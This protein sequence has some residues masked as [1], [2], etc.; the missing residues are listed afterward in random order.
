MMITS[1][2]NIILSGGSISDE[3]VLALAD[4][5]GNPELREA[6]KEITEKLTSSAFDSCSIINARS[7]RCGENCKWCAQSAHYDTHCDVYDLVDENECMRAAK[8]N[9]DAGVHRFSMVASGKATR[10]VALDKICSMLRRIKDEVGIFTCASLGLLS[11][12]ELQKL[13]DAGVRRYHCNLEAAPEFFSTLCTTHTAED[14]I[15]TILAA[16]KIGFEICS[17][18]IIGMGENMKQRAELAVALRRIEPVSIPVNIL[19]PI[20]GT[21]LE[22]AKPLSADEFLDTLAI[23]R[24]AHPTLQIRFAGGRKRLTPDQQIEAMSIAVNGAIVGDLLTTVGATIDSDRHLK[25]KT[26]LKW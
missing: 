7:G 17:G 20:K 23:F 12:D 15:Q 6:A 22:N 9:K 5:A 3:Q 21:P 18:G 11:S 16:K 1:L 19:C 14:K 2:K 4:Y 25:E 13:W 10:G 24:F 8:I 26:N